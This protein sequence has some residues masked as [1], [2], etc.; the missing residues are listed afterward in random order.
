MSMKDKNE[1]NKY[2]SV[3][4]TFNCPIA[5]RDELENLI[6]E[7]REYFSP[8]EIMTKL[9]KKALANDSPLS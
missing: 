2:D 7:N 3:K 8:D 4:T 5:L 6:N 1:T 9:L